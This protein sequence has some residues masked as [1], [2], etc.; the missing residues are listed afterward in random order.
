MQSTAGT[1]SAR[2]M[3]PQ[4]H[5]GCQL[6]RLTFRHCRAVSA[7]GWRSA[8]CYSPTLTCCS[9]TNQPTIWTPKALLGSSNFYKSFQARWSPSPTIA[10]SWTM[11]QAGSSNS[12]EDT[13]FLTRATIPLGLKRR[14][15]ACKSSNDK[16]RLARKRLRQ[17]WNG[18][19]PS[20]RRA[21]PRT[22]RASRAL[23]S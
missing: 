12:T 2:L 10:T 15:S 1:W 13:A 23:M 17:N 6:M 14:R 21:K 5:C 19:E 4:T 22:G 8:D 3:S 7:A 16:R 20:Q 9:L 18:C 11:L